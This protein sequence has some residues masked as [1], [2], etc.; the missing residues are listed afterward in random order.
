MEKSIR[1]LVSEIINEIH[2]HRDMMT[3]LVAS[4][5]LVK[6]TIYHS[7]LT[8]QIADKQFAFNQKL[9]KI[10]SEPKISVNKAQ[11]IAKAQKE[12]KELDE[13]VRFETSLIEIIRSLKIFIR[14]R[15]E[16]M[17]MSGN[18]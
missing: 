17:R 16:E 7:N 2:E 12:F 4:D 3:P 5:R 14:T 8:S 1:Q 10:I 6:L 11:I 15:E 9:A 18:M 13:L